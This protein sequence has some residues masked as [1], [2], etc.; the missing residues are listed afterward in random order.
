VALDLDQSGRQQQVVRTWGGPSLG[1]IYTDKPTTITYVMDG[2]GQ[3]LSTGVKGPMIVPEW[4]FV[5]EWILI[6]DRVSSAVVDIWRAAYPTGYPPTVANSITGSTPPTL[7]GQLNAQGTTLTGW[8][9]ML[10][11]NDAILYNI[12]SVASAQRLTLILLCSRII[13]DPA[14]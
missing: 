14:L 7:T 9:P 2:G 10:N 3:V 6:A 5:Y 4:V 11:Q 13:G 1:W 12:N 8:T